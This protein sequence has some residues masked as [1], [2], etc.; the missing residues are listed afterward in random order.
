M[1]RNTPLA[2]NKCPTGGRCSINRGTI[3]APLRCLPVAKQLFAWTQTNVCLRANIVK[4]HR[5]SLKTCSLVLHWIL[6][7]PSI[8]PHF[9]ANSR[10]KR[11]N[12]FAVR[13][14]CTIF[15][16]S[17]PI[18]VMRWGA[19]QGDNIHRGKLKGSVLYGNL[20]NPL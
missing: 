2:E 14:F 19:G 9:S 18:W 3:N 10:K 11:P 12:R 5:L 17:F 16:P 13:I 15:V 20:Q 6:F 8:R 4:Q 1:K 7:S